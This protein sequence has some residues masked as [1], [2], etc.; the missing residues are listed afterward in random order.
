[1]VLSDRTIARLIGDGR[2]A[3]DPHVDAQGLGSETSYGSIAMRP[4]P[5]SLAMVRSERTMV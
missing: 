5:M 2:I 3:I 4:S 1:M